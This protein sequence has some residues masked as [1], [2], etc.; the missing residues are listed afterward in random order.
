MKGILC[1]GSIIAASLFAFKNG[2]AQENYNAANC[3][4]D[5]EF[6][7]TSSPADWTRCDINGSP[8][9][10]ISTD[11]SVNVVTAAASGALYTSCTL[12][13]EGGS[14]FRLPLVR[15]TTQPTTHSRCTTTDNL[16]ADHV[17]ASGARRVLRCRR[18]TET[19]ARFSP[20][21]IIVNY[22]SLGGDCKTPS[23]VELSF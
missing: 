1:T 14:L 2:V 20:S 19:L 18:G 15:W 9:D 11:K 8:M 22:E 10:C 4:T 13:V 6:N 7:S 5:P 17:L 21:T 16:L 3:G 23:T 12:Y